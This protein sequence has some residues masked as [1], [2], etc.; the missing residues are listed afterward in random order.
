MQKHISGFTF[1]ITDS[2]VNAC[3]FTTL[4]SPKIK[5][6]K[7]LGLF[8]KNRFHIKLFT[9][10]FCSNAF[11]ALTRHSKTIDIKYMTRFPNKIKKLYL[12]AVLEKILH[13]NHIILLLELNKVCPDK[14]QDTC[15]YSTCSTG[16]FF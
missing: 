2:C 12:F 9:D 11:D 13:L 3:N 4:F 10:F 7:I 16:I 14:K 8:I 1:L 6:L 5:P 15:T